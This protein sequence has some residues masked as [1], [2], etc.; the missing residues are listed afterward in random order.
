MIDVVATTMGRANSAC[1]LM[2]TTSSASTAGQT[3]GP[4]ALK[5]YAVDPVG[6]AA[7]TP[8]QPQRDSGRPSTS[9][10]TSNMRSRTPFS[11][12]ASLRAQPVPSSSPSRVAVTSRVRRSS[13]A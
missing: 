9:T 8:S 11:T 13:T 10:T 7:T 12:E 4:P 3:T 1:A 2:G 6:V 5:A